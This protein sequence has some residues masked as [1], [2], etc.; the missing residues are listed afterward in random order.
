MLPTL[1]SEGE[2]YT[3]F[4]KRLKRLESN[5]TLTRKLLRFGRPII[6]FKDIINRI[7]EN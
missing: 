6:H 3:L 1:E 4:I 2:R 5:M 7:Q